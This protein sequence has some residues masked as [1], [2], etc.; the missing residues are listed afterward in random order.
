MLLV[1]SSD[2]LVTRNILDAEK[3]GQAHVFG[4][5]DERGPLKGGR[6]WI[7]SDRGRLIVFD[8]PG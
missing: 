2:A 6:P 3:D 4:A 1:T 5:R 7:G 8:G